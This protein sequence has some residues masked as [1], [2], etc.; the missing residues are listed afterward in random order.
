MS[1]RPVEGA[2][3]SRHDPLASPFAVANEPAPF[4]R[5]TADNPIEVSWTDWRRRLTHN[6]ARRSDGR[7]DPLTKMLPR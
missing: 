4:P 7:W 1:E 3:S 2:F 6:L 5:P